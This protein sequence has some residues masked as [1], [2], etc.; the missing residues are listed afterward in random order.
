MKTRLG[1]D[2]GMKRR[3]HYQSRTSHRQDNMRNSLTGHCAQYEVANTCVRDSTT[4]GG[5]VVPCPS[6]RRES[7]QADRGVDFRGWP[8]KH[9][10]RPDHYRVKPVRM[11]FPAD[12]NIIVG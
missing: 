9:G 8:C 3:D 1:S 4:L 7:S 11:E 12:A 6:T 5:R 10:R 2:G